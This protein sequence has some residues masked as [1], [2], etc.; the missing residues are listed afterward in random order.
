MSAFLC[1]LDRSGAT[2]EPREL[3]RLSRPLAHHG[4]ASTTFHRGP[5]GIVVRH[6]GGS[7]AE[8]RHG[9]RADPATGTVAAVAGRFAPVDDADPRASPPPA[10]LALAAAAAS[11][12]GSD[13]ELDLLAGLCGAFALV[14]AEPERGRVRISRDPLGAQKVYYFLDRRFLVAASEPTALLAHPAVSDA[15]DEAEAARFLGFR[16]AWTGRSFYREVRELPP[17]HRLTVA[18]DEERLERYWRF[19]RLPSLARRP[20]PEVAE[21]FRGRLRRAV[22]RETAGLDPERVALSL[23]GGL[24]S[25]AIAASAPSGIRA[26]SWTFDEVPEGDERE[27]VRAV[28]RRLGLPVLEVS[29]DGAYPL[30]SGFGRFVHAAS[31]YL[32]PFALLKHRLYEAA[33]AEGC[34]RVLVGDGGDAL[35]A[36]R[37][38]WLAAVLHHRPRRPPRWLTPDGRTLLPDAAP[39]PILPD[40]RG[41]GALARRHRLE[42]AAGAKNSE[43]ESEERRLFALCGIERGN[44]F[45]SWP[46]LEWAAQLPADRL[47]RGGR[48][49]VLT[50]EAFRGL[51]PE[52]VLEGGRSGILGAFFLR[53]IEQAREEVREVVFRRPRS[54]WRRYVRPEWVEAYLPAPGGSAASIAFGHTILWRVISYELWQR[55]LLEPGRG[56]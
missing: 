17:G 42:L 26:Y 6:R 28:S 22:E 52:E 3:E 11:A 29:G 24:D 55:K 15:L 30:S 45:W 51:L 13:R 10:E 14:T 43:I 7:N 12:G 2:V 27:R 19:R 49:K 5:V 48:N 46:L 25:T 47:H 18:A 38:H 56:E 31:P 34:V 32:N 40:G 8:R 37:G 1:L 41:P 9:P 36:A 54:D 50:R 33:R 35:Y 21:E 20:L 53:G 4:V 16:F 39:S 44:P 23:S